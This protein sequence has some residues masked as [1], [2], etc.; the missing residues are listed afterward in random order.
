MHGVSDEYLWLALVFGDIERLGSFPSAD[1]LGYIWREAIRL[2]P[3]LMID[4]IETLNICQ[5]LTM[6]YIY[7]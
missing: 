5:I 4:G 1:T 7:I 2:N 6:Y 3:W